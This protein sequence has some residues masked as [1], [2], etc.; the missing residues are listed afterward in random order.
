MAL[1]AITTTI[2]GE[3]YAV[4]LLAS[5]IAANGIPTTT[6]G[7]DLNALRR[8][9][10][11]KNSDS[12]RVGVVT[13]AGSATMTVTLR[14]WGRAGALWFRLKDLNASSAAPHTAVAIPET[15]ADAIQYS[16]VV[17]G[18]AGCDRLYLEIV[19][20]AGTSTAVTGYAIVGR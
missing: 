18:V 16:E 20:I 6:A 14:V 9:I 8:D 13:T 2:D 19:A 3:A 12:V 1:G 15:S 10:N 4:E 17:E 11:I 7:I 5:A